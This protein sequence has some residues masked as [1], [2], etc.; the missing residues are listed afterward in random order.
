MKNRKDKG[1]TLIELLVVIAIIGILASML[2]PTLAKAKK[3]ANRLK[4]S[5]NLKSINQA[6]AGCDSEY[7]NVPWMITDKDSDA[8]FKDAFGE[9]GANNPRYWNVRNI[10][11]LWQV[12]A[13][14]NT[15]GTCA[16][17]LSPSDP[18]AKRENDREK[19]G[20]MAGES[21]I[22][23]RP[24]TSTNTPASLRNQFWNEPRTGTRTTASLTRLAQSYGVCMGGDLLVPETIMAVTRNADGDCYAKNKK[25]GYVRPDG[26]VFM[27]SHMRWFNL[28]SKHRNHLEL[29]HASSGKWIDPTQNGDDHSGQIPL[30]PIHGWASASIGLFFSDIMPYNYKGGDSKYTM[31]GLDGSQGN[32]AKADGSVVQGS[33]ADMQEAIRAHTESEGGVLGSEVNLG[34][35]RPNQSR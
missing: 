20:G 6:F 34:V 13:L 21:K 35:L 18:A 8:S 14:R 19:L 9:T 31:N 7:G 24:G 27:A 17:V 25:S 26:K 1:F 33:D 10:S 23:P 15:L 28:A 29:N 32:I 30:I 2:L 4:C 22:R 16:S 5:G 12:P 3:K 11:L